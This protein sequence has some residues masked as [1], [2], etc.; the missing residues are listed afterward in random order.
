MRLDDGQII[1]PDGA[2]RQPFAPGQY[3]DLPESERL[4]APAFEKMQSGVSFAGQSGATAGPARDVDESAEVTII[5]APEPGLS[6]LRP[7]IFGDRVGA[8]LIALGGD[9]IT[10][11]PQFSLR[12]EG[13]QAAGDNL[14]ATGAGGT[15]AETRAD[16]S[17]ATL[18]RNRELEAA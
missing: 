1:A 17:G 8:G 9:I 5:D 15:W 6:E 10:D 3:L 16:A 4:S 18:A 13:W 7:T 11:A 2:L 14:A 12:D